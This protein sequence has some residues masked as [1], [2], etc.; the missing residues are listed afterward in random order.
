MREGKQ[1]SA[2][3][4]EHIN[5]RGH[6]VSSPERQHR[7]PGQR[8][9]Q[10][11][12][13]RFN[14]LLNATP[15]SEEPKEYRYY[16]LWK[17][18]GVNDKCEDAKSAKAWKACVPIEGLFPVGYIDA[19]SEGLLLLTDNPRFR[20]GL[21]HS[22][23]QE[24]RIFLAQ[25]ELGEDESM[26]S[27]EA[28]D[29]IAEGVTL[30]DGKTLPMEA[31]VIEDPDIPERSL[32]VK[33]DKNTCWLAITCQEGWSR[34]IRRVTAALGYPTLRLVQWSLGSV[35]LYGM[36]EGQLRE[37]Q[38]QEMRWVHSVLDRT[39]APLTPAE[40]RQFQATQRRNN[41]RRKPQRFT[42]RPQEYLNHEDRTRS[43]ERIR[44]ERRSS[45]GRPNGQR[46]QGHGRAEATSERQAG[47]RPSSGARPHS[48]NPKSRHSQGQSTKG[49]GAKGQGSASPRGPQRKST[50]GK[51]Q[52]MRSHR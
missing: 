39:P 29:A 14:P 51:G 20:F 35:S 47:R 49:H 11:A 37:L 19:S 33:E 18:Y 4:G 13:S 52:G 31:E 41:A 15:K 28:L 10:S 32:P 42:T 40:R 16:V 46:H 3:R 5:M 34:H 7:R 48:G 38:H 27:D 36:V 21:N 45:E 50:R 12:P 17:P 22:K 9:R 1:F 25:V 24:S 6:H 26:V 44:P 2:K 30:S 23:C 8:R 43:E